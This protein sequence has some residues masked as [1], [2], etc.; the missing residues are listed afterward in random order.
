MVISDGD[1]PPA[2]PV[3]TLSRPSLQ[4][5]HHAQSPVG[6]LGRPSRAVGTQ[7]NPF[8]PSGAQGMR[9]GQPQAGKHDSGESSARLFTANADAVRAAVAAAQYQQKW[10]EGGEKPF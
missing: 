8:I 5:W 3:L 7:Q 9:L 4:Q 1:V 2:S 10:D 6:R